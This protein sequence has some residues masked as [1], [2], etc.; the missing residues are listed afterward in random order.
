[1]IKR[2]CL[3]GLSLMLTCVFT[4]C[5]PQN[6]PPKELTSGAEQQKEENS[7]LVR[8]EDGTMTVTDLADVRLPCRSS[9]HKSHRAGQQRK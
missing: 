5:Q 6:Q 2:V 9:S 3:L 8:H 4:A 1:M 7:W